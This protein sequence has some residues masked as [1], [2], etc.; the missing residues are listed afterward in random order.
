MK[1]KKDHFNGKQTYIYC[2]E[3]DDEIIETDLKQKRILT[4]VVKCKNIKEFF[5]H[6]C[7]P[8]CLETYTYIGKV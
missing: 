5:E 4:G 1:R 2:C 3:T 7:D 6:M 8:K